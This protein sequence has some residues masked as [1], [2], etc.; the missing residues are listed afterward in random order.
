ME[1]TLQD[2]IRERAHHLWSNDCGQGDDN[3]YWLM[4]EREVLAEI[5]AEFRW[6]RPLRKPS[7]RRRPWRWRQ[8]LRAKRAP[9]SSPRRRPRASLQPRPRRQRRKAR[10]SPSLPA[11]PR[12]TPRAGRKPSRHSQ[13]RPKLAPVSQAVD[14]HGEGKPIHQGSAAGGGFGRVAC[15][16]Q[17][18]PQ[19][20]GKTGTVLG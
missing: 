6:P 18:A 8:P 9:R 7:S 19:G 16:V 5:A 3:H 2:R 20:Y 11:S 10:H 4:A 1:Q 15:R 14:I 12:S 13:L 17:A